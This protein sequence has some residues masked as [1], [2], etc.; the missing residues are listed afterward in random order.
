MHAIRVRNT[1]I[2]PCFHGHVKALLDVLKLDAGTAGR[3]FFDRMSE[4]GNIAAS[5]DAQYNFW[6][7]YGWLACSF[8]DADQWELW[9]GPGQLQDS[10]RHPPRRRKGRVAG[11]A[12]A[13]LA[14]L[15]LESTERDARDLRK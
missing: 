2:E 4:S 5:D 7:R 15:L 8:A 9:L 12:H 6:L 10:P 1:A 3:R 14:L 13:R 11:H